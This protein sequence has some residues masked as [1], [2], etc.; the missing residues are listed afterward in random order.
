MVLRPETES[1]IGI[2]QTQLHQDTG[3]Q[4]GRTRV[5]CAAFV[6]PITT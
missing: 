6:L 5:P 1:S 3:C 2:D 4:L